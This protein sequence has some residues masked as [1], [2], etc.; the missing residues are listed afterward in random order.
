MTILIQNFPRVKRRDLPSVPARA[1]RNLK[2]PS[3]AN[4]IY[5]GSRKYFMM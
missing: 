2:R 4:K 5:F 1:R 3:K